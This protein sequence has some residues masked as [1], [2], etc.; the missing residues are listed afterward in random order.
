MSS[1]GAPADFGRPSGSAPGTT[2]R[3][4]EFGIRYG[5]ALSGI[6]SLTIGFAIWEFVAQFIVRDKLFLVAPSAIVVRFAELW[7]TGDIQ[8]H[9][10]VSGLEFVLGFLAAAV[11]GIAFGLLMGTSARSRAALSPWVSA[12]YATP[13]VALSPLL[14][15]WF[16]L[17]LMSKVVVVFAVAVFPI[18]VNTQTGIESVD[19]GLLET[20]RAF[21]AKQRQLFTKVLL[22]GAVPFIV[23]GL[24][25][26]IGRGLVGVVVGELFGARAGVGY[27]ITVSSQIFDM[28]ALFAAALILAIVG[29]I[30]TEAIRYI[31]R[32]VAPWRWA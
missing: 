1:T 13:L 32:K 21:G 22:P 11:V 18:L 17:G 16:G 31:E 29:V 7:K 4:E 3:W 23:A 8:N 6:I 12:I 26:G 25:L 14:I 10:L 24:R 2:S 20:A 27:L 30:S 28:G 15:L 19:E 9:M 5:G